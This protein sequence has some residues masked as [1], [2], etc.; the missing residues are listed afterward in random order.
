MNIVLCLNFLKL[1]NSIAF[2]KRC[3]IYTCYYTLSDILSRPLVCH[4]ILV[5][6]QNQDV[7]CLGKYLVSLCS[8]SRAHSII[9]KRFLTTNHFY[10]SIKTDDKMIT[11]LV[12]LN[13]LYTFKWVIRLHSYLTSAA[14]SWQGDLCSNDPGPHNLI[15]S[16]CENQ[17]KRSPLIL[18]T[19]TEQWPKNSIS[20]KLTCYDGYI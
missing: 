10:W 9:L 17:T 5:N 13:S 11:K 16:K 3:G 12:Q 7:G 20:E 1:F 4:Q 6:L 19:G 18:Y 8:W 15:R 2:L 14:L